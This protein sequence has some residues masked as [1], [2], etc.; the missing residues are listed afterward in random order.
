MTIK[1][2]S[3]L[4]ELNMSGSILRFKYQ[5]GVMRKFILVSLMVVL[6]PSLSL[7]QENK[8]FFEE[9]SKALLFE[10]SGFD[11][12]SANSFNGGIGG[13]YFIKSNMAI[14]G[15]LQFVNINRDIPFQGTGGV[16]GEAQASQYGIFGA[17][18][19]HLATERVSPFFG[20]GLSLTFASTKSKTAEADPN[21]QEVTKNS[22][23]GEF[24]YYGGSEITVFGLFGVELFVLK[25][26][27]LAAEYRL[28]FS[29]ISLKDEEV[30]HGNVT[31]TTKQ[32]SIQAIGVASSGVLTLAVYF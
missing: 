13:K 27:S 2:V 11:N 17:V 7:C 15:G 9:K 3:H 19:I 1:I 18:E 30:T 21:D 14:R 8:P 10:F 6:I 28:G 5:G 32:G 29:Q 23:S 4:I 25:N 20:G 26:L 16:D 31:V 24:G 12:L 22:S